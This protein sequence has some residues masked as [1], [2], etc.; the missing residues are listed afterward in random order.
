MLEIMN[1]GFVSLENAAFMIIYHFFQ[2]IEVKE[3][4][5]TCDLDLDEDEIFDHMSE[6][7]YQ[8]LFTAVSQIPDEEHA[9]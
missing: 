4:P 9:H 1:S 7:Y 2:A 6:I 3:Y 8:K 5:Q